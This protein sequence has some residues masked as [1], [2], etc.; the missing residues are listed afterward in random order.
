LAADDPAID[1]MIDERT[2]VEAREGGVVIDAQLAAWMVGDLADVKV[3][4]VAPDDV[5]FRRIAER[6]G[7]SISAAK[8]ETMARESIQKNR[9]KKYYGVD[10]SD[11]SIYDLKIDTSLYPIEK[12]KSVITESVRNLLA[13]KN[14]NN[15][16]S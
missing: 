13:K 5:R 15:K 7:T 16:A 6:D 9:Y 1:K 3:L 8:K 10:V 11:L 4:I 14:L 12:A 2:K